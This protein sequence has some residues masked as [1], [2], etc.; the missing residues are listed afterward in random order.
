MIHA[1]AVAVNDCEDNRPKAR[2]SDWTQ[3]LPL[4]VVSASIQ[5]VYEEALPL[6]HG[7]I[8]AYHSGPGY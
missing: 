6:P 3:E 8:R 2:C 5:G 7:D 1:K 4:E